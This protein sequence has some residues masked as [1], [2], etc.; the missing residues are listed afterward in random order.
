MARFKT[1]IMAIIKA[2]LKYDSE[3]VCVKAK[4]WRSEK[5]KK[6]RAVRGSR[7]KG[8]ERSQ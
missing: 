2:M 8:I 5:K 1:I 6:P 3:T 4:I 7:S